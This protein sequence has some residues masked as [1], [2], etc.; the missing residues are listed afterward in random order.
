MACYHPLE[1]WQLEGGEIVFSER[2]KISRAL[3]LPCGQ[4]V[5]CRLERSRQ[6]AVRCMHE[7][8]LHVDNSFITLTY[9]DAHLPESGSLQYRDFQLF[10]K[11][12]RKRVDVPVRFYMCGEYGEKFGRPHYHSILFGYGFRDRSYY[13]TLPSGSKIYQSKFLES[14]W[15]KGFSSLGDVTFD[16][17]AYVARYCITDRGRE[18][19]CDSDSGELLERPREFTRM[20]LKPGIG[21]KFVEKFETDIFPHGYVV[22]NGNKASPP[23]Y[24][25]NWF[26][27]H[28]PL[29]YD[30]L[31]FER[32]KL[33]NADDNT[34]ARLAVRE[35]VTKGRL[36]FK[37]RGLE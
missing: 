34:R 30:G 33:F 8:S 25:L 28:D 16:S 24:Y 5:G 15:P 29:A 7:A 22:V 37:K 18:Y 2:G 20:S 6:W 27:V 26:K 10:M 23:R 3:N 4:C 36:A 35:T 14:L 13:R 19:I 9:D 31:E 17:A 12:L 32:Q 1:A 21:R 11:L